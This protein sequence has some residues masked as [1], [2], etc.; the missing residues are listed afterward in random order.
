MLNRYFFIISL[1]IL[2]PL[3]FDFIFPWLAYLVIKL[4][5]LNQ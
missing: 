1:E 2:F 5:S 4:Q 3:L